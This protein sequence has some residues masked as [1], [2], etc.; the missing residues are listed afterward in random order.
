[1]TVLHKASQILQPQIRLR[2]EGGSKKIRELKGWMHV[3]SGFIAQ[4]R[5]TNW[6]R[7][8]R[9]ELKIDERRGGRVAERGAEVPLVESVGFAADGSYESMYSEDRRPLSEGLS[10]HSY[11]RGIPGPPEPPASS[12]DPL[13][14]EQLEQGVVK[15]SKVN[16]MA[17]EIHKIRTMKVRGQYQYSDFDQMESVEAEGKVDYIERRETSREKVVQVESSLNIPLSKD[18]H[19][20]QDLEEIREKKIE[21]GDILWHTSI[22]PEA[23]NDPDEVELEAVEAAYWLASEEVDQAVEM[24]ASSKQALHVLQVR[25][26]AAETRDEEAKKAA[27]RAHTGLMYQIFELEAESGTLARKDAIQELQDKMRK[28]EEAEARRKKQTD[29]AKAER[30]ESLLLQTAIAE[31]DA[32]RVTRKLALAREQKDVWDFLQAAKALDAELQG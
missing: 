22:D 11:P 23:G 4:D 16:K 28:S 24:A 2:G 14:M 9:M 13:A 25:A 1:V 20:R 27:R 15:E 3:A 31:E 26:E 19:T 10:F 30:E 32:E 7:K 18:F 5:V 6:G 29:V 21:T 12:E 8:K 17:D